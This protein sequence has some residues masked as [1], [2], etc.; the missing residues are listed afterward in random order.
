M[1]KFHCANTIL[2]PATPPEENLVKQRVAK[3]S[4]R[5]P[6]PLFPLA[7]PGSGPSPIEK[8]GNF[9]LK[10]RDRCCATPPLWKDMLQ[11]TAYAPLTLRLRSAYAPLTA[12]LTGSG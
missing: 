6:P 11:K 9:S 5:V 8:G 4:E 3:N 2:S 12:P 1:T 10:V 7:A